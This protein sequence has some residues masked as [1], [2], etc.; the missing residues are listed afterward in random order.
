MFKVFC[1]RPP[2]QSG[3][4]DPR[5]R[6]L[7]QVVGHAQRLLL[8]GTGDVDLLLAGERAQAVARVVLLN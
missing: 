2:A 3:E 4:G 7:V 6:V 5:P 1:A 8:V